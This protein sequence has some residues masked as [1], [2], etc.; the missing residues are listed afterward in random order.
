MLKGMVL[1]QTKYCPKCKSAPAVLRELQD[2]CIEFDVDSK[3]KV[4]EKGEIQVSDPS[5]VVMAICGE[6][7]HEWH[8]K[9]ITQAHQYSEL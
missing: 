7:G 2:G 5:G 1:N 8:V 3:G 6:C 4:A 9:G